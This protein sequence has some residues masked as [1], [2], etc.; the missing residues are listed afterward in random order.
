M[1]ELRIDVADLLT[2]PAARRATRFS[3]PVADLGAGS[4]VIREP[5]DLDLMLERVREG[6]VARGAVRARY[7]SECGTCLRPV[8]AEVVAE[9]SE[10]FEDHPVDGETYPLEGHVVD[11]EQL[12]RDALLL[13]LPLAPACPAGDPECVAPPAPL[14]DA[15]PDPDAG[16]ETVTTDPRWAALSTLEL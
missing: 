2:H 14:A 10:L 4:A 7:Q 1:N 15:D 16:D 11:L 9:V 3:A 8:S 13:E 6:I 5:V 12:T